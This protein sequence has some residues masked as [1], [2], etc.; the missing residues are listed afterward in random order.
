MS[1]FAPLIV[2]Q[3]LRHIAQS[4]NMRVCTAEQ[5]GTSRGTGG[6]G[7]ERAQPDTIQCQAVNS[8]RVYLTATERTK[9]GIAEII[10][11][12]D[13]KVWTLI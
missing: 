12:N 4:G 11:N 3:K 10:Y 2:G 1:R 13:E 5:G 6:R 7:I 9:I 8:G